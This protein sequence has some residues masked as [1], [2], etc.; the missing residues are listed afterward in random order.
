MLECETARVRRIVEV[1][2]GVVNVMP[3]QLWMVNVTLGSDSLNLST[4]SD[5]FQPTPGGGEDIFMYVFMYV[6]DMGR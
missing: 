1:M 5:A 4:T 3:G 2:L 6:F